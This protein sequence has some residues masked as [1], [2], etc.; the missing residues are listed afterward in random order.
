MHRLEVDSIKQEIPGFSGTA[1]GDALLLAEDALGTTDQG[2]ERKK[3]IIL[4][5]DGEAN[6]GID[7]KIAG[8]YVK[9]AGNTIYTIGIGDPKGTELY[10]TDQRGKR[11]Y[12]LDENGKPIRASIDEA[13]L[14]K[15]AEDTG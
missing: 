11:Q 14:R 3:I 4:V 15:L 8:E 12:F 9:N 1:I 2:K 5:T 13:L 6:T 7:P 10:T